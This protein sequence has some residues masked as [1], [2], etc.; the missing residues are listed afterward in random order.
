[1]R[2]SWIIALGGVLLAGSAGI[3][4]SKESYAPAS[5]R[6]L[7]EINETALGNLKAEFNRAAASARV[8]L[9]LSPT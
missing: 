4:L 3:Y 6:P 1:M 7:T 8:I 2:R 9:L 5:Q